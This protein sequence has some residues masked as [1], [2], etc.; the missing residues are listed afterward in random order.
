MTLN[1]LKELRR[2]LHAFYL[3][4]N[5]GDADQDV[6]TTLTQVRAVILEMENDNRLSTK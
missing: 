1:E 6:F 3:T 5:C 4:E 2:L